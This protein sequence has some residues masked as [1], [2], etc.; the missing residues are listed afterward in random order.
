MSNYHST[1]HVAETFGVQVSDVA[2]WCR[3][4]HINALPRQRAGQPWKIPQAEID[5]LKIDGLPPSWR[6]L[7]R[8]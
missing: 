4:G 3:A 5:R 6:T 2:Y 8:A 7:E 1:K